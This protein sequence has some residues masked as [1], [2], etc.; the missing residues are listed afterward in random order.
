M[1]KDVLKDLYERHPQTEAVEVEEY[2]IVIRPDR[3]TI[4]K[5]DPLSGKVWWLLQ[6]QLSMEL[7][8]ARIHTAYPQYNHTTRM[9][10]QQIV[11]DLLSMGL[12]V[13]NSA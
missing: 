2:W 12:I 13:K 4:T 6:E 3:R 11:S 5:L 7:L 8:I 10:V 9:D 1:E